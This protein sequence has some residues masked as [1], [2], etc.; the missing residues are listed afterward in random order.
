MRYRVNGA[1]VPPVISVE[2]RSRTPVK[3]RLIITTAVGLLY[4]LDSF[5]LGRTQFMPV[6]LTQPVFFIVSFLVWPWL[7]FALV[8][9]LVGVFTLWKWH[10]G[11]ALLPLLACLPFLFIGSRLAELG[12]RFRFKA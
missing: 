7:S 3:R 5:L 2:E 1:A 12:L 4:V 8:W 6:A 11:R 9:N 10:S